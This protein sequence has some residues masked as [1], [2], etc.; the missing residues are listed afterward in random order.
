M[1]SIDVL[2]CVKGRP[3]EPRYVLWSM[4]GESERA[5][6]IAADRECVERAKLTASCWQV[7]AARPSGGFDRLWEKLCDK[8]LNY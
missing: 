4:S 2:V 5:C 7:L 8:G 6:I 1:R 3:E